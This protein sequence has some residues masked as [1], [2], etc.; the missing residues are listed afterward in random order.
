MKL[1]PYW[2]SPDVKEIGLTKCISSYPMQPLEKILEIKRGVACKT[3]K[4]IL[5]EDPEVEI[6]AL[7]GSV[8]HGDI[9]GWFSDIDMLAITKEPKEEEMIEVDHEALFV[10]YHSWKSLEELLVERIRRDEYEERSSYLFFY[11]R[12]RYLH[13]SAKAE[14]KYNSIVELGI[15]ALWKDY[16]DISEYLDDFIWFYGSV[17]EALKHGKPL[18]AK[19]KLQRGSALL[20]RHYLVKNRILLRKPLPDERTMVQLRRSQVPRKLVDFIEQL[21][22]R[23]LDISTMLQHAKEMYLQ[24]TNKRKW[25]NEIPL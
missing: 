13:S 14:K 6:V 4:Q 23:E 24:T 1:K 7:L 2:A 17:S 15:K 11:G 22:E 16:S 3:C 9:I 12:P 21:Y 10:E 25:L 18:T 19:G 20:L 5:K 8:A